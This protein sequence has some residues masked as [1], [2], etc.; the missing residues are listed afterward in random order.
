MPKTA[1]PDAPARVYLRN[2][3]RLRDAIARLPD[4]D[5]RVTREILARKAVLHPVEAARKIRALWQ[6]GPVP[7]GVANRQAWREGL[8]CAQ[9]ELVILIHDEHWEKMCLPECSLCSSTCD[10]HH[11]VDGACALR[12]C[13]ADD[14][15][16]TVPE[17]S[18]DPESPATPKVCGECVDAG[19]CP[20]CAQSGGD[21][22][23]GGQCRSCFVIE[24][25]EARAE[26]RSGSW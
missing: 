11:G 12:M 7:I 15:P 8:P 17:P 13:A 24:A 21:R 6:T 23:Y 5:Y 20:H 2:V 3:Q 16:N 10:E 25:G 1:T 14:C 9:A 19:I 4:P 18:D 22:R 26:E